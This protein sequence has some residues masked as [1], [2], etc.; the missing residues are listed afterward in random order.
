MAGEQQ[1]P[2]SSKITDFLE[3]L[4][5]GGSPELSKIG[6]VVCALCLFYGSGTNFELQKRI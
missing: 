4:A 1:D 2:I 5:P 6:Q 3:L